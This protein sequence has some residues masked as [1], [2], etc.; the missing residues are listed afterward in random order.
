MKKVTDTQ[1]LVKSQ[2]N[3]VWYNV[4]WDHDW[5]CECPDYKRQQSCKHVYA[6]LFLQKLPY[7]IL[8]N[9]NYDL[10]KCPECEAEPSKIIR[11]G[12][13]KNKFGGSVSRLKCTACSKKFTERLGFEKIRGNPMLVVVALDLYYK[14]LSNREIQHHLRTVCGSE[15]SHMAIHRW[16]R[17]FTKMIAEF[18]QRLRPS[19][20]NFWH[21]D[22]MIIKSRNKKNYLWN[23]LDRKTRYLLASMVTSGRSS[24]EAVEAIKTALIHSTKDSNDITL[25]S[26]GLGSYSQATKALGMNHKSRVRFT[27]G[28]NNNLIERL[29]GFLRKRYDRTLGNTSGSTLNEGLLLYHNLIKPHLKLDGKTPADAAGVSVAGN[30]RWLS[31]ILKSSRK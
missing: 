27:D 3:E 22:D 29:N 1:Y 21:V 9:N 6:V 19:V 13:R 20:G 10:L 2:K 28:I 17:R 30:N 11:I 7:I 8:I 16:V 18:A 24:E 4:R 15:V 31:L 23:I 5:K 12:N 14:G 26:D 25:V